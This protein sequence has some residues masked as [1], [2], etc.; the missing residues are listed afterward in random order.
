MS[1]R[2]RWITDGAIDS[3]RR[4]DRAEGMEPN[5]AIR[6]STRGRIRPIFMT[7][8]TTVCAMMPLVLFPG[9]GS[10]L[11]RGLGSVVI[12][13]LIVSTVFTLF[14]V[15]ALFSLVLDMRAAVSRRLN[16]SLHAHGH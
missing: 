4:H 1:Q 7:V 12:G 8:A 2:H 5:D 15:P 3:S 10:E 9:A 11:Y 13:G 16:A 14:L 6:E